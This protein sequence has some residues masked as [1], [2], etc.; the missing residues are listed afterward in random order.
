MVVKIILTLVV[1]VNGIFAVIFIKDYIAHKDEAKKEPGNVVAL[2]LTEFI[3][4]F[5]STFGISDF[6]VGTVVYSKLKWTDA[7]KLPGTLNAECVIPVAVMAL[8]YISSIEVDLTT[9]IVAILAQVFGAYI[10]PRYV[11]KMNVILI[12]KFISTGLLVA[13]TLIL[14]GKFGLYPTGG[15]VV[16]LTGF[17]LVLLGVL[18]FVYGALNNVGIG[19]YALTMAT[20]YA[21]GLNPAI[22]FP[23]MMGACTF[24][25][26][27][28]SIQFIK[29]DLY[30][31]KITLFAAI[32]GSI[33]VLVAAF[34][35]KSL[36]VAMLQ[37][38]VVVV[39]IY[40]AFTMIND[41][42][43]AKKVT[44]KK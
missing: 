37:W 25:V 31:R 21:L 40:S 3:I 32:F 16:G 44:I 9:L 11:V 14:M 34:I 24:S 26:P 19:S 30:A 43:K 20:V 2:A 15:E 12:K 35:V 5:L 1:I 23:I 41:L 13:A 22:A 42:V 18:S 6:A 29:Y 17:K 7:K 4:F 28:G 8:A 27:I 38:V 39:I 33:G 36:N 10:G